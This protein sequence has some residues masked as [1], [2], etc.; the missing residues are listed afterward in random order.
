VLNVL[1]KKDRIQEK[2]TLVKSLEASHSYDEAIKLLESDKQEVVENDFLF[3]ALL[4]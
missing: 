2:L 3:E 1:K 4:R